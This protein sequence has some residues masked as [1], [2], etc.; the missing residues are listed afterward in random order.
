MQF[1]IAELDLSDSSVPET[2]QTALY[3]NTEV[4]EGV[5]DFESLKS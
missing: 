2:T 4:F 1:E 5:K 3:I